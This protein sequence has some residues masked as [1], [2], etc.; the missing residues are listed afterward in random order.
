MSENC[1]CLGALLNDIMMEKLHKYFS[2]LL[3]I[4]ARRDGKEDVAL[5]PGGEFVK[6]ITHCGHSC[7]AFAN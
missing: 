6:F 5:D 2:A 4:I 3:C 7:K 1:V